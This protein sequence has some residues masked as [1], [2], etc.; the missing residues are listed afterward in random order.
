M[1]NARLW[2][3]SSA[4]ESQRVETARYGTQYAQKRM[5]EYAFHSFRQPHAACICQLQAVTPARGMTRSSCSLPPP[6]PRSTIPAGPPPAA[7]C[8]SLIAVTTACIGVRC[9]GV[10]QLALDQ[11][12]ALQSALEVAQGC[13]HLRTDN[14][15]QCCS[16]LTG[17]VVPGQHGRCHEAHWYRAVLGWW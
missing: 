5:V 12:H 10:R 14:C 15:G 8:A 11:R 2:R 6:G 7:D 4:N 13:K 9:G 3:R 1:R 16:L 17:S